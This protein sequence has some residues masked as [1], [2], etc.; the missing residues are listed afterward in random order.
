MILIYNNTNSTYS[1][2]RCNDTFKNTEN[3]YKYYCLRENQIKYIK[4]ITKRKTLALA[5]D[6]YTLYVHNH[7]RAN[8]QTMTPMDESISS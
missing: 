6:S 3:T 2:K 8:T 4:K 5:I 1:Q 7:K